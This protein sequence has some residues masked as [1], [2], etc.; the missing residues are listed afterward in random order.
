MTTQVYTSGATAVYTTN[1][2]LD[3]ATEMLLVA[4][5]LAAAAMTLAVLCVYVSVAICGRT[6]RG[7]CW[8]A[9]A[10]VHAPVYCPPTLARV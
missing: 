5:T 6:F 8:R 7:R 1:A 3:Y 10:S 4:F 2:V 9:G